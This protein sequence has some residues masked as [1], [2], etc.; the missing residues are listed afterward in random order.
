MSNKKQ[1][2]LKVVE[3]FQDDVNKGI[4]R[5]DSSF[6]KKIGVSSG[7]VVKIEG[8]RKTVAIVDRA[9][10]GDLGQRKIRMDGLTRRNAKT[11]IGETVN[12]KKAEVK[13]AKKVVIA[14]LN[15]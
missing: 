14:P 6:M 5:I 13:E 4:V 11:G 9:Y 10:P 3:A 7:D 8:A 1:V 2:E 12:V 15:A